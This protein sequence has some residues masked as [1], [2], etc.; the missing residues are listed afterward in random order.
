MMGWLGSYLSWKQ[1]RYLEKWA[2]S[3][4]WMILLCSKCGMLVQG[5]ENQNT[6]KRDPFDI[7][8]LVVQPPVQ[9]DSGCRASW[10]TSTD[11]SDE[12]YIN[13]D[14]NCDAPC[15]EDILI[16]NNMPRKLRSRNCD[17]KIMPRKLGWI[18][19]WQSW[20]GT[21][22]I[23]SYLSFP[24]TKAPVYFHLWVVIVVTL[25]FDMIIPSHNH[26]G[27]GFGRVS[28]SSEKS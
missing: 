8:K 3:G 17:F 19:W 18:G 2:V 23:S 20:Q 4:S 14:Q 26:L 25:L 15:W 9:E 7:F 12:W 16:W 11:H 27:T 24:Q 13:F 6:Q 10:E 5:L 22:T 1:L 21:V 28:C